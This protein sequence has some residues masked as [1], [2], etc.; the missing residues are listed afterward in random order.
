MLKML[1]RGILLQEPLHKEKI[2]RQFFTLANSLTHAYLL[3]FENYTSEIGNFW[4]VEIVRTKILAILGLNLE[5]YV[6]DMCLQGC[7]FRSI[8]D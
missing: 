2:W 1:L 4:K 3:L 5:R 8:V 7:V 6:L